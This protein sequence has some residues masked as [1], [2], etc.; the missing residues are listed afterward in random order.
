MQEGS[1]RMGINLVTY[2]LTAGRPTG[3]RMTP[4]MTERVR[5]H[6]REPAARWKGK[7]QKALPAPDEPDAWQAPEGWTQLM[8]TVVGAGADGVTISFQPP[9][10]EPFR[11]RLH[12][13]VAGSDCPVNLSGRHAVLVDVESRLATGARVA[14]AFDLDGTPDY[15][16]TAP[17]FVRPGMN[18]DLAFDLAGGNL[19]SAASNW[20]YRA[21][22]PSAAT[23]KRIYLVVLPQQARGTICFRRLRVVE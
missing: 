11:Q 1:I 4:G 18:R 17:L 12:K 5:R 19:K 14:L 22:F 2:F 6:S 8:Q 20:E 3:F 21:R 15:I 10:D 16:E 7:P 13:A 9:A 23:V